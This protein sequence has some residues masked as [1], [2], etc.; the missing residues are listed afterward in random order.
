M[1]GLWTSS[2][3]VLGIEKN[4]VVKALFFSYSTFFF[5]KYHFN[6]SFDN[7]ETC[8]L[9]VRIHQ[10]CHKWQ[11]MRTWILKLD[12]LQKFLTITAIHH[13]GTSIFGK[14][15]LCRKQ[16][17]ETKAHAEKGCPMLAWKGWL[18]WQDSLELQPLEPIMQRLWWRDTTCHHPHN[19]N[20]W[21]PLS[22]WEAQGPRPAYSLRGIHAGS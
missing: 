15:R 9:I 6:Q 12:G 20:T 18:H 21:R 13:P 7:Y 11:E 8:Q 19:E 10:M 17:Y 16:K 4:N 2:Q 22:A 1:M 14:R 3:A 5:Q